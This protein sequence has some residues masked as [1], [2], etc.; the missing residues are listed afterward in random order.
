M[1]WRVFAFLANVTLAVVAASAM[2]LATVLATPIAELTAG[3][4]L[5]LIAFV[6]YSVFVFWHGVALAM[7]ISI[8]L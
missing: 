8:E 2:K 3:Q 6:L 5:S 4:V 7:Y 1:K